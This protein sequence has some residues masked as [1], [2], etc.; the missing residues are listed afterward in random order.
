MTPVELITGRLDGVTGS[1]GKYRAR[2]PAHDGKNLTLSVKER[3]D[4]KAQLTCYKDCT[5]DEI[6]SAI[7]LKTR[8]LYPES[9][10]TP[11]QRRQY[12]KRQTQADLETALRHELLMLLLYVGQRV[13]SRSLEKNTKFRKLRPEW[14]PFPNEFWEREELAAKRIVMMIQKLY[15]RAAA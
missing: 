2:C 12:A 7:G 6:M 13:D 10:F 1:N 3:A 9:N 11:I 8:D 14:K 4:G 15:Q 5:A